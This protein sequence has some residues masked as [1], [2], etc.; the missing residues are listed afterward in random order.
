MIERRLHDAAEAYFP[1]A[2][3]IAAAARE[4]LPA[5]PDLPRRVRRRSLAVVLAALALAG[6][7]VAATALDLVPGVRVQRV[8]ELPSVPFV[9][10]PGYGRAASLM[11]AQNAVP[12]RLLLP[13]ALGSPGR[14]LLD[15]DR[16][17]LPSSPPYY[18]NDEQARHLAEQQGAADPC[19]PHEPS[20]LV[21][22]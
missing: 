10:F 15:R 21:V 3:P 4:R 1:P 14:V 11:Q 2:P 13:P 22:P 18:G 16:P 7:A 17:A 9:Q 5:S 19:C 6:A 20:P 8:P 12:F